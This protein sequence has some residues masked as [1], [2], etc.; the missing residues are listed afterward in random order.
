MRKTCA[1]GAQR[2]PNIDANGGPQ[3]WYQAT[4]FGGSR[5]QLS[6]LLQPIDYRQGV[7]DAV[8]GDLGDDGFEVVPHGPGP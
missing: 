6:P 2:A 1:M 7:L 5:Q 4:A 8:R 3:L